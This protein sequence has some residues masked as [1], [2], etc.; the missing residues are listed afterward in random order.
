MSIKPQ[1]LH[2]SWVN[3][4]LFNPSIIK[5]EEPD[6]ASRIDDIKPEVWQIVREGMRDGVLFGTAK[7]LDM[8]NIKI[9]AKTG[10]AE[11]GVTKDNVN[12]WTTGFFPYDNP[13]Y[14]F[15]VV[16]EK[17]NRHNVIGGVAVSRKL[18]DWMAINTPEYFE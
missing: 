15:V 8:P 17:G 2:N 16:M 5:D 18:F 13:K 6:I 10:T 11:L 7:G 3:T 14:A 12:S 9:A 1:C 4:S